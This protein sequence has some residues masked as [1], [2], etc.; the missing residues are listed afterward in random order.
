VADGDYKVVGGVIGGTL[1]YNWQ[2]QGIVVGVESD[3]AWAGVS[4]STTCG[5]GTKCGTDMESFGTVRGRLGLVSG[6]SLFLGRA[7]TKSAA[8]LS[9][10]SILPF[11]K[12]G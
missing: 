5:L 6:D 3:F 11:A 9:A 4:G 10:L 7:E 2:R 12:P 8:I 1:G